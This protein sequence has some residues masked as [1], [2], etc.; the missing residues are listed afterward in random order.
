MADAGVGLSEH[1][2]LL[3]Y[4]GNTEDLRL[5]RRLIFFKF[6]IITL[7]NE[8]DGKRLLLLESLLFKI[9]TIPWRKL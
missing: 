1:K 4:F 3:L 5:L 9:G 8:I 6:V 2:D 7:L